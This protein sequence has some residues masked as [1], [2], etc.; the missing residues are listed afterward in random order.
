MLIYLKICYQK[1]AMDFWS[2]FQLTSNSKRNF[3]N[4]PWITKG[5][6]TASTVKNKLFEK[7]NKTKDPFKKL[8]LEDKV[9]AY[10]ANL[11]KLIRINKIKHYSNYFLE[12]K[13]NLL[14]TWDGIREVLNISKKSSKEINCLHVNNKT[15]TDIKDIVNEFNIHFTTVFQFTI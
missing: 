13:K 5:L 1:K 10:K 2:P 7:M 4:K 11:A 14:N 3:C 9:K 15:I 12:N 6:L 8:E